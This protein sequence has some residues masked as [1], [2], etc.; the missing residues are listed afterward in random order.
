[1]LSRP[2]PSPAPL[3]FVGP[4]HFRPSF[5]WTWLWDR[6]PHLGWTGSCRASPASPLCSS[7]PPAISLPS[8]PTTTESSGSGGRPERLRSGMNSDRLLSPPLPAGRPGAA[9]GLPGL[10][11]SVPSAGPVPASVAGPVPGPASVAGPAPLAGLALAVRTALLG[12]LSPS[13]TNQFN[14]TH[15]Q[16]T[17]VIP[18]IISQ[19]QPNSYSQ[20]QTQH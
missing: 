16:L 4:T 17:K 6:S 15:L 18:V 14:P 19:R 3:S 9:G 5:P 10:A 1:M 20:N 13:N 7:S 12:E 2:P 11:V 8:S